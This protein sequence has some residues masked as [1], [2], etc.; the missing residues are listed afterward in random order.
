[1]SMYFKIQAELSLF[2][3]CIIVHHFQ[4][5]I[6]HSLAELNLNSAFA[7]FPFSQYLIRKIEGK[8]YFFV[9]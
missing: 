7:I 1:M 4:L 3:H 9:M 8:K 6:N 5:L 2:V